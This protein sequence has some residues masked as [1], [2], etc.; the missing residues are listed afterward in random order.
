MFKTDD[1]LSL[2]YEVRGE[3]VPVVMLNG[4]PD[5][6]EG[7]IQTAEAL[8]PYFRVVTY[9]LRNQGLVEEGGDGYDTRRH[10]LD[11][12]LLLDHL[13][14]DRFVGV[15]L[16]MGAR[17]LVDFASQVGD[18]AL[19]FVLIAASNDRLAPRYRAIFKSWLNALEASPAD[20]L[21]PFVETFVPWALDPATFVRD[22]DFAS[23]YAKLLAR[24]HTRRGLAANIRALIK[25]YE[26]PY[27]A[28]HRL[29]RITT[30][31][32]FIQGEF[33][34]LTP[35]SFIREMVQGFPHSS[36]S[37]IPGSGH[38]VRVADPLRLQQEILDF[39]TRDDELMEYEYEHAG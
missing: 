12:A 37:V 13:G 34:F 10:V 17:I 3:G 29:K 4:L 9:N 6:K 1:G 27:L 8:A 16:S 32:H 31:T 39:L 11:L 19:R 21:E 28:E 2:A 22:P 38:N 5:T 35:P 20:D 25:S 15:G 30:R 36:V 18:R 14:V 7:W 26:T 24:T 33:D 23:K